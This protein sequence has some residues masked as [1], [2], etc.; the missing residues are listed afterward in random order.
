MRF[1][2]G[3]LKL[4]RSRCHR[5]IDA[6][7]TDKGIEFGLTP[8][9]ARPRGL[10]PR[11]CATRLIQSDPPICARAI[12]EPKAPGITRGSIGKPPV[13]LR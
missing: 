10:I 3:G 5:V 9:A 11:F 1:D 12:Q 8:V 6:D 13:E 4:R 2:K 7:R